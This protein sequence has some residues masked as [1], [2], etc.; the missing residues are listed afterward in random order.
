MTGIR[1]SDVYT[2]VNEGLAAAGYGQAG[3]PA[4]PMLDAGPS[5]VARLQQKSPGAMVFLTIGGGTGTTV[6]GLYDRPFITVRTVGPQNDY[7]AA[8]RLAYDLDDLFLAVGGN[9]AIGSARALYM[10]RTGG[11]PQ[12]IDFDAGERYH[13]QTT[14]ITEAQ[15]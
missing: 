8:E 12:L 11:A 5:S 13:F 14:Y 7:E 2:F 10:T 1:L 3:Q 15:R 6:E 9:A 4:M